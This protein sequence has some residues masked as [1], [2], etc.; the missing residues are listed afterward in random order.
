MKASEE[1]EWDAFVCHASEDKQSFVEPLVAELQKYGLRI[2]FDKFTLH[3]GSSLR[4]SIDDGLAK[5]RFGIVVLSHSFFAKNWPQKELNALFSRQV[6]GHDVILPIWHELTT[7]DVLRYSP[8]LSDMVATKSS[9][10]LLDVA[11]ALVRVI[12]PDALQFETSSTD[13][14]NAASRMREQLRDKHPNL[15]CRVT[16]GPQDSDQLKEFNGPADPADL[17]SGSQEGMRIEMFATDKEAYNR[18][19][20]TFSLKMTKDAWTKVQEV[21]QK[22]KPVELGPEEIIEFSSTFFKSLMPTLDVASPR[23]IVKPSQDVMQRRFR[24]KLTFALADEREEFPYIEFEMVQPGQEE[25]VIRSSASPMPMKL[26]L[27]LNLAGEPSSFSASYSYIGHE[28]RKIYKSHRAL[29]LLS[30]GG[31]MEI[32]DLESDRLVGIMVGAKELLAPSEADQ[33]LDRFITALHEVALAFNEKI[34]WASDRTRDDRIHLQFLHYIWGTGRVSVPADSITL[35]LV[36][37]PGVNIKEILQQHHTL[38]I[39]QSEAPAFAT[40]FGKALDVGPYVLIVQP[41]H[42]E[43][44]GSIKEPTDSSVVEIM[45]AQPLIYEFERF[46]RRGGPNTTE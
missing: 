16:L 27:S 23:V 17:A 3:V 32:L 44:I 12:R 20:L 35:T 30:R 31:T 11:R 1:F 10:G 28:I 24:F 33:Y 38:H 22:G 43:I 6:N 15:D 25:L 8:L 21:Q 2:W 39:N 37:S 9:E 26:T 4:E 46:L 18:N 14:K 40:V 19:P 45:L 7:E 41:R 29:Q 36:P 13:A 5:S 42:F 34:T